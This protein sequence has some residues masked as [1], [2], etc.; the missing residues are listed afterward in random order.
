MF[1][2]FLG[3]P[4]HPLVVHAAVVFVPL[5]AL[6]GLLIALWPAARAKFAPVAL[7]IATVAL[8]S[9]PLATE[10]GEALEDRVGE[11]KL[12]ETHAELADTLL[13]IVAGLWLGLAVLVAV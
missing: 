9:I 12:V 13:P 2:T 5:A 10:S 4:M 1:D 6:A 11:S 3:V 7:A 8:V